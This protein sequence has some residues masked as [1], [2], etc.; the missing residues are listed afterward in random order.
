MREGNW[1]KNCMQLPTKKFSNA[2]TNYGV[3]FVES[4]CVYNAVLILFSDFL[5]Q[6]KNMWKFP[7]GLS[8]PGEDIG[9]YLTYFLVA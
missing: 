7:G 4:L 8:E 9:V 3:G 5:L 6:L 1:Q 2:V